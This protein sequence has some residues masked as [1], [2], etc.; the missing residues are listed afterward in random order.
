MSVS[1][2]QKQF[3]H[4]RN[5]LVSVYVRDVTSQR[6]RWQC[7]GIH[8]P[9]RVQAT[10]LRDALSQVPC[11]QGIGDLTGEPRPGLEQNYT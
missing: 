2:H 6:D 7:L 1:Q 9:P 4:P 10:H 8:V 5:H 3:F 11:C